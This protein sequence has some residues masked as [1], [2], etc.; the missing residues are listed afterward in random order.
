MNVVSDIYK[1]S[2]KFNNPYIED[3]FD[4]L[5][6]YCINDVAQLIINMSHSQFI[7]DLQN[8]RIHVNN[9]L[10]NYFDRRKFLEAASTNE[11]NFVEFLDSYF[12][13]EEFLIFINKA[14]IWSEKILSTS[15]QLC[16]DFIKSFPRNSLSIEHH[17]IIGRYIRT[18]F[19]VHMDDSVDRVLH[20]NLGPG[21][22]NLSLWDKDTYVNANGSEY[23]VE[24][25]AAISHLAS[26]YEFR[27]GQ[28]FLLPARFYH[29]GSSINEISIG[30]ALAFT[31]KTAGL[32]SNQIC[33][34]FKKITASFDEVKG[35]SYDNFELSDVKKLFVQALD[36]CIKVEKISL[37]D[38]IE[39]ANLREWSNMCFVE[40]T[41]LDYSRLQGINGSFSIKKPF[42]IEQYRDRRGCHFFA[43]GHSLSITDSVTVQ[44]IEDLLS[45]KSFD[46]CIDSESDIR[47]LDAVDKFKT[48]LVATRAAEESNISRSKSFSETL[49]HE[50]QFSRCEPPDKTS[51]ESAFQIAAE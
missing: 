47:S 13:N 7:G 42:S 29:I 19:G 18:P 38:L 34:E 32:I 51:S 31:K 37:T 43:R 22:K 3:G 30:V 39:I 1:K 50:Q 4:F 8:I 45:D 46:L 41:V 20:I 35:I 28:G 12:G 48:W 27:A 15:A 26:S 2:S 9:R 10:L 23:Y 49:Q 25:D 21:S 16:K 5:N 44:K 24:D 33:T 40:R 36:E 14:G 17:I 11:K 6:H